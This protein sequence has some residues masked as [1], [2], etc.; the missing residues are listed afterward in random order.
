MNINVFF[1]KLKSYILSKRYRFII[2]NYLGF[3]KFISDEE[4]LKKLYKVVFNKN[5]NLELPQTYSEKLQW[6]KLHNR[7]PE[8][9]MMVDKYKVRE[10]ISKTLGD[11]Y[12]IPLLGVWD[13][14]DEIDFTLLPDQ[15]VLKCNHDSGGLCICKNKAD[16][17]IKKAKKKLRKSLKTDYYLQFREWPYKDIKRKIIAEEYM[18]D[19]SGTEL[20]D[21]KFFCFNGEPK[22][23][24][25]IAGRDDVMTIDFYDK[26]WQH[27]N[28]HE[29]KNYPFAKKQLAKPENYE[30]ML[31][32][33]EI[34]AKDIPFSRIDFY[35]INGHVYF[36]EITFFPTT[37]IGG[38][39]PEEWDLKFGKMIDLKL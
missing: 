17:N 13:N 33:A 15:F 29:P 39:E 1:S 22:Y 14:P 32:L 3:Y 6:L 28:F 37:G 4:F 8:Y 11:E 38:F 30:L 31:N 34:L 7:K 36:G 24:Q 35:N 2:N 12:L 18:V 9:T 21:Y 23:C 25:V 20:K 16:F 27:Q 5:L 10:Y 19:E 26:E